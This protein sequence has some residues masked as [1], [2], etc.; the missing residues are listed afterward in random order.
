M[1]FD[2]SDRQISEIQLLNAKMVSIKNLMKETD[3]EAMFSRLVNELAK[4]QLEY[5]NWFNNMQIELNVVTRPD[6]N[7]NV[8]FK[9]KKLQLLG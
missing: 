8:D 6:Q 3:N 2:L 1:N 5:D 7:W 4:A 9:A